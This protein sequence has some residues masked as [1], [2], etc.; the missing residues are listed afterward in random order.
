MTGSIFTLSS[1]FEEI[2]LIRIK[3]KIK[4]TNTDKPI[5]YISKLL[6]MSGFYEF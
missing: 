5:K 6:C 4:K 1:P 2:F 3:T